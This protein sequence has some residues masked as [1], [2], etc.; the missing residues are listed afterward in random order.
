MGVFIGG[1]GLEQMPEN[2]G[3]K[4]VAKLEMAKPGRCSAPR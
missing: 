4:D 2:V 1:A 3:K